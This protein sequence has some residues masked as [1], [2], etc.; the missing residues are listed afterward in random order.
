MR[1]STCATNTQTQTHKHSQSR[2]Y[3]Q[4]QHFYVGHALVKI[5]VSDV[6]ARTVCAYA[7]SIMCADRQTKTHAPTTNARAEEYE[8]DFWLARSPLACVRVCGID[9]THAASRMKKNSREWEA[10]L[11]YT[12]LTQ[13]HFSFP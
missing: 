6:R 3:R 9:M 2:T 5:P 11:H 12:S 13:K 7:F 8:H 4:V 10:R 1:R